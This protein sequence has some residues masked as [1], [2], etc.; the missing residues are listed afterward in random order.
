MKELK[1]TRSLCPE[2]LKTLDASIFEK[3]GK[4]W[5]TKTCPEHGECTEVY[6]EDAE[7]YHKAEKWAADG[8]RVQGSGCV[9]T[10]ECPQNC[11]LCDKH[12]SNTCL[13]NIVITNRCDLSCWYCFFF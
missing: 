5:I 7:M 6:W 9:Q 8:K 10:K 2:C 4:I 1:K 11:G 12:M 13:G 3:D